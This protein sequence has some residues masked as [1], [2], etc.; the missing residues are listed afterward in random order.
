MEDKTKVLF[1]PRWY[2]NR[3]DPMPGLFIQRQAEALTPF[4]QVAV[5]YIHPDANCPNKFE[6]DFAVENEVRVLRVYFNAGTKGGILAP[7]VNMVRYY[8]AAMR[9]VKSIRQFEPQIVHA[10]VLTRIGFVAW[11]VAKKMNVPFIISEHWSRYYPENNTYHGPIRKFI[12]RLIVGRAAAFIPVSEKLRN[13]MNEQ[14]LNNKLTLVVPNVVETALFTPRKKTERKEIKTMI[15]VSCF[16]DKSKN[17]SGL[18]R[19]LKSLSLNRQDFKC[20]FVGE[21]PDYEA[22]QRYAGEL[23]IIDT[24]AIFKG[25]QEPGMVAEMMSDADFSVLSSHY[26]TF[27][28]VLVESLSCGIPVVS[29]N[30]GIA[31]EI[32]HDGNGLLVKPGNEEELTQALNRMLDGCRSFS[33]EGICATLPDRY[34]ENAVAMQMKS[35]YDMV[36]KNN[37][38]KG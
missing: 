31:G 19:V 37:G 12:T 23:G 16:D 21:G 13:A 3:Y 34:S 7:V 2:P 1:L 8:R 20:C 38:K 29:S 11:R 26:E 27:G 33:T 10:H 32:I 4:C 24:F 15:H 6:V 25:G 18:L 30:T 17:I 9:A 5:V 22:M 36:L 14:G 35:I 28:T